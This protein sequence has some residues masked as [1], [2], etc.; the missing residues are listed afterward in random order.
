M[1]A[2]ELIAGLCCMPKRILLWQWIENK[3]VYKR[4][5]PIFCCAYTLNGYREVKYVTI[6]EKVA[7]ALKE[8][9]T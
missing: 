4:R 1:A 9:A 3:N 7:A 8:Q 6:I 2:V 5:L